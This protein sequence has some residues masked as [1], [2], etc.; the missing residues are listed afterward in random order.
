MKFLRG[1]CVYVTSFV[2]LIAWRE[3]IG[4]LLRFYEGVVSRWIHFIKG[5]IQLWGS[6]AFKFMRYGEY[7]YV[8]LNV[9]D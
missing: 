5:F 6:L 7:E 1:V 8:Q 2:G 3:F 9:T 4:T